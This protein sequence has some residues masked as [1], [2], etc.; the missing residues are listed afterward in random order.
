MPRNPNLRI[1]LELKGQGP[2]STPLW[3]FT[4]HQDGQSYDDHKGHPSP[5]IAASE[6]M[7]LNSILKIPKGSAERRQRWFD[8]VKSGA[9]AE[10]PTQ[11]TD[12]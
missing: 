5:D 11:P 10:A 6:A 9:I 4:L 7:V 1:G 12:N 2:K 3:F 8:G